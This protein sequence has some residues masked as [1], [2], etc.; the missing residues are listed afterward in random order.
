MVHSYGQ[1]VLPLAVICLNAL[2]VR[3]CDFEIGFVYFLILPVASA[4]LNTPLGVLAHALFKPQQFINRIM[5]AALFLGLPLLSIVWDFYSQPPISIFSHVW[6]YNPGTLYDEAIAPDA[7][8]LAWRCFTFVA[9]ILVVALLSCFDKLSLNRTRQLLVSLV[10]AIGFYQLDSKVGAHY[11]YRVD[12]T[13]LAEQLSVTRQAPGLV[14]HLPSGTRPERADAILED[15]KFQLDRLKQKLAMDEFQTIHSYVYTS[16]AMK[17]SLLGGRNTMFAKPWLGEIHIHGLE[18]PHKVVAHELVHA[19]AA[20]LGTSI[21]QVTTRFGIIPNMGLIEGFAEAF[22]TPRGK[23]GLHEYARSMRDLNL[24]PKMQHLITAED[25]WRQA[26]ARAYTITG[27]FVRYLLEQYGPEPLKKAYAHADF[28]SA[29]GKNLETLVN[30][31][32]RF[33]DTIEIPQSSK[34][35][36]RAAFHRPAIFERPCAHVVADLRKQLKTASVTDAIGIHE[37]ICDFEGNTPTA[38]LALAFALKR[39]DKTAEFLEL[40]NA[41]FQENTLLPYQKNK[42]YE[43]LGN[44]HWQTGEVKLAIEAFEKALELGV[45]LDSQRAQWVKLDAIKRPADQ[46]N[47]LMDYL[48]GKLKRTEA[49]QWLKNTLVTNPEDA[50]LRY[51]YGRN[52]FNTQKYTEA[53]EQLEGLRHPFSLI[54]AEIYRVS[55]AAAWY[56]KQLDKAEQKYLQ[57]QEVAPN[58]GEYERA[59]EWLER[60]NWKRKQELD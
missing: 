15:H 12:R 40:S 43:V 39:A 49:R 29:F 34:R 5:V 28:Q 2:R 24:A 8:L 20:P 47:Q 3:N 23:L 42:L 36:A 52:L 17:G 13:V 4:T 1:L 45:A 37:K 33:L 31:W 14:I 6:G 26:P 38:R 44:T 51:L 56:S 41:L 58:S 59:T 9:T 46:A 60:I 7:R 11:L 54:Q 25:F 57:F 18:V 16:A 19:V 21:L 27:S 55:A 32:N 22:T 10:L 50:T 48:L 35:A 53:M 30:E